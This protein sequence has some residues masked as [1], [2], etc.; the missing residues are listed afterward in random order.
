MWLTLTP[1][2]TLLYRQRVLSARYRLVTADTV[3]AA[4][5]RGQLTTIILGSTMVRYGANERYGHGNPS[6]TS[7]V[8]ALAPGYV[9]VS[10]MWRGRKAD[11]ADLS[12]CVGGVAVAVVPVSVASA[13]SGGGTTPSVSIQRDA[14]FDLAGVVIHVGLYVRC[15]SSTGD[16]TVTVDVKQYP[17]ET[18]Y[19]V[20]TGAT[21]RPRRPRR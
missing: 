13:H 7:R 3:R 16:G 15:T 5:R 8:D 2:R 11:E 18:P 12:Q 9:S 19:P 1:D 17:P 10:R 4:S 20:G 21:S 6:G 14:Q